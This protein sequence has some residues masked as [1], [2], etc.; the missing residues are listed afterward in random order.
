MLTRRR[1]DPN[2]VFSPHYPVASPAELTR[3]SRIG[4]TPDRFA[5]VVRGGAIAAAVLAGALVLLF[6]VRVPHDGRTLDAVLLALLNHAIAAGPLHEIQFTVTDQELPDV[7]LAVGAVALWFTPRGNRALRDLVLLA[8]TSAVIVYATA[9]VT[10][11]FI[12]RPRPMLSVPM[13]LVIDPVTMSHVRD[14]V[15][16]FGSLPS[17]HTALMAIAV[18]VAFAVNR[19]A[20]IALMI[21]ALWAS[22][23]RIAI[24]FHWPSDAVAGALLGT[25]V[26]VLLLHFRK[27]AEPWLRRVHLLFHRRPAPAYALAFF[28]LVDFSQSFPLTKTL[29]KALFHTRLFH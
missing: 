13:Q 11:H 9:R 16:N 8:F 28:F 6:A 27:F 20:A 24:G 4:A 25:A 29:V 10:Q 14:S 15:T 18:V 1:V 22:A 17:D 23:Y 5:A 2:D 19:Q 21:F 7:V 12:D 26:T 3:R